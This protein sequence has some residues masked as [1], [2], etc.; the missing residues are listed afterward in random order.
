MTWIFS[1]GVAIFVPELKDKGVNEFEKIAKHFY[2]K[3]RDEHKEKKGFKD[4]RV[5]STVWSELTE[6]EYDWPGNVRELMQVIN[7]TLIEV[8]GKNIQFDDIIR[9]IQSAESKKKLSPA[10]NYPFELTANEKLILRLVQKHCYVVRI[11]VETKL[12]CGAT[13]A[14]KIL[15]NLV[16]RRMIEKTGSGKNLK[17]RLQQEYDSSNTR[18]D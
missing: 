17:Y 6:F 8:G 1:K 11:D 9:R 12:N 18:G 7:T 13:S 14:W 5:K 2:R 10:K 3:F 4:V 16:N 15:N